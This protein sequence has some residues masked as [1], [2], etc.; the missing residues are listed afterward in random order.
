MELATFDVD[1]YFRFERSPLIK[2]FNYSWE[3][4][5]GFQQYGSFE[6]W[7]INSCVPSTRIQGPLATT[8]HF[9]Q[10]QQKVGETNIDQNQ[11]SAERLVIWVDLK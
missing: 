3:G 5:N 1:D 2:F 8:T 9:N 10:Y 6:G 4:V 7:K 11:V